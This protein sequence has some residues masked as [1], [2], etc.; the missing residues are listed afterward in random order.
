MFPYVP[1]QP[2]AAAPFSQKRKQKPTRSEDCH[3][4]PA[5]TKSRSKLDLSEYSPCALWSPWKTPGP[6]VIPDLP[7]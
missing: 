6:C 1:R 7:K 5:G 4:S 2:Y 3:G